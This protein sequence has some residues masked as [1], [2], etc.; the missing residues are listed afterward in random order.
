[1]DRKSCRVQMNMG[2]C[3]KEL[4]IGKGLTFYTSLEL[5]SYF[6]RK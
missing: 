4:A 1:M 3:D 5:H 6:T 2:Y